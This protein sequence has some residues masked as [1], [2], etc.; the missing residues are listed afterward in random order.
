MYLSELT[1]M[2]LKM[3]I[4]SPSLIAAS[5][6]YTAKKVLKR[7]NAWN[8]HLATLIGY[9]ERTVRDCAKDICPH[10]NLAHSKH[11]YQPIF[12]KFSGDK[13]SAV[14]KIAASYEPRSN[15]SSS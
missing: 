9:D 7:S 6:I 13:F 2:D 15:F 11:D 8:Y 5:C 14:A 1:L 10:L 3:Y 12:K 4:Y